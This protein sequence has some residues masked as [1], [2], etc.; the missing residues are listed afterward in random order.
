[1]LNARAV[2]HFFVDMATDKSQDEKPEQASL[3]NHGDFDQ[4]VEE[5]GGGQGLY[6]KLMLVFFAIP[7]C[8]CNDW[9]FNTMLYFFYTP[10]HW[11]SPPSS[12]LPLFNASYS[13]D[14][15][16]LAFLPKELGADQNMRPSQCKIYDIQDWVTIE[17]VANGSLVLNDDWP[18]L[19]CAEADGY[20]YDQ[21]IFYRTFVS[22]NDWVCWSSEE[23]NATTTTITVGVVFV[24]VGLIVFSRIADV[25]GRKFNILLSFAIVIVFAVLRVAVPV[26]LIGYEGVLVFSILSSFSSTPLDQS[27]MHNVGE[28]ASPDFR[29]VLNSGWGWGNCLANVILATVGF[30]TRD[31][32]PIYIFYLSVIAVVFVAS[33][34]FLRESPRWLLKKG[35]VKEAE[36]VL[37]EI[38]RVNGKEAPDGLE[39]KL[40]HIHDQMQES[41][42]PTYGYRS[43][44]QGKMIALRTVLL[45]V[46][47][48]ATNFIFY[49][50]VMNTMNMAG[51]YFVNMFCVYVVVMPGA[52]ISQF[53]ANR[54]G[55]RPVTIGTFLISMALLVIL[56]VIAVNPDLKMVVTVLCSVLSCC[57]MTTYT[58]VNLQ[59]MEI[60]PTCV[61]QTGT[62]FSHTVAKAL[63]VFIPIVAAL[64]R[65]NRRLPF[66]VMLGLG[67]LGTICSFFIPETKGC[68]LPETVKD[69]NKFATKK[70][71]KKKQTSSD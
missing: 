9:P 21:S 38:A 14:D 59:M 68:H 42:T 50:L 37:R 29:A 16:K 60:Y 67:L 40:L 52:W 62:G 12:H 31:W 69:A 44:F 7:I 46:C 13:M 4:L 70:R 39:E 66:M 56:T 41:E 64:G 33:A 5:V 47:L 48:S 1:M 18:Q 43:L 26:R 27:I 54:I 17:Q 8:L 61:R 25:F 10:D 2:P 23:F 22:E 19:G 58:C 36:N 57:A 28:I 53:L 49:Q 34:F 51:D 30:F 20:T 24:I 71:D 11:C 6:Q 3:L 65:K 32:L 35:R 15:W 55:R 63:C 45:T